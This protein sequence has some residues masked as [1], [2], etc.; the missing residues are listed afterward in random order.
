MY[1][2]SSYFDDFRDLPFKQHSLPTLQATAVAS[3]IPAHTPAAYTPRKYL[4][5]LVHVLKTLIKHHQK[6]SVQFLAALK[7]RVIYTTLWATR[8]K[9]GAA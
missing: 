3:P 2:S 6:L 7:V 8:D 5:V 4:K 1:S 9:P